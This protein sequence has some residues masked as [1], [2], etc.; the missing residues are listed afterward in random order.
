MA[1]DQIP[2]RR[3]RADVSRATAVR[4]ATAPKRDAFD[5]FLSNSEEAW[6]AEDACS[7]EKRL[8]IGRADVAWFSQSMAVMRPEA[9]GSHRGV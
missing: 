9:S 2:T 1:P 7:S 6:T 4:M 3:W 8:S 5:G